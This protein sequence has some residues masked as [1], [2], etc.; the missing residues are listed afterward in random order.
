MSR[1]DLRHL[2]L[3]EVETVFDKIDD[4]EEA[5]LYLLENGYTDIA[6]DVRSLI[7]CIL[8]A[9]NEIDISLENLHEIF[10]AIQMEFYDN[11]IEP[12]VK[13]AVDDYRNNKKD[14]MIIKD[15]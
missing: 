14:I 11:Y 10:Y 3:A 1:R 7:T 15:E 6:A 13:A 5:E 8:S 2:H 12:S 4:L 9:K